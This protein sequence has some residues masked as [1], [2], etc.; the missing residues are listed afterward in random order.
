LT[1]DISHRPFPPG[2][3]CRRHQIIAPLVNYEPSASGRIGII[4]VMLV[5]SIPPIEM[6]LG[7]IRLSRFPGRD[8]VAG[9][10]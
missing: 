4:V 10:Q 6:I 9:H 2:K 5:K 1:V 8:P 7:E 3:V